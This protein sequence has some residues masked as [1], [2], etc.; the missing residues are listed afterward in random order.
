MHE[1]LVFKPDQPNPSVDHFR[2]LKTIHTAWVWFGLFTKSY[3]YWSWLGLV[4]KTTSMRRGYDVYKNIILWGLYWRTATMPTRE[5]QPCLS[6]CCAGCQEVTLGLST[7]NERY[8]SCFLLAV[9]L[10]STLLCSLP[11]ASHAGQLEKIKIL[12]G[13]KAL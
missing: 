6:V 11:Q 3:L 4:F 8:W 1:R 12:C 7:M 9:L 2:I 13:P 10:P 5:R